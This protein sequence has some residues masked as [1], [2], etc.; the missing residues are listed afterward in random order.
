MYILKQKD[1][2][3]RDDGWWIADWDG[4]PGRTLKIENAKRYKTEV[5]A[6]RAAA[7]FKN[8]CKSYRKVDLEVVEIKD[9]I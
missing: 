8:K 3:N 7:Y 2:P 5:G 9:K 1:Q 4:D 6:K